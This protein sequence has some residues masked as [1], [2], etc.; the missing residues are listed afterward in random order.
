MAFFTA[1][2]RKNRPGVHIMFVNRAE[3]LSV[4]G[5]AQTLP[6]SSGGD[7][8]SDDPVVVR[9]SVSSDGVLSATGQGFTLGSGGDTVVF[10]AAINAVVAGET[11]VVTNPT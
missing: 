5:D 9:L 11:I 7:S 2:E 1:G 8:G 4:E 6:P 3:T 10:S